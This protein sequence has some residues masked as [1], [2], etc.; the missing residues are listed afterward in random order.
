MVQGLLQVQQKVCKVIPTCGTALPR[1]RVPA[2]TW[3]ARE[4]KVKWG[5]SAAPCRA[6]RLPRGFHRGFP[7]LA[8]NQSAKA[9]PVT[10]QTGHRSSRVTSA[11]GR[12][13][14]SLCAL[15][16]TRPR[17]D[18]AA[19]ATRAAGRGGGGNAA[20]PR[21]PPGSAPRDGSCGAA[22]APGEGSASA[23]GSVPG[24]TSGTAAARGTPG[25]GR[26]RAAASG[27]VAPSVLPRA[28]RGEKQQ[29]READ[30]QLGDR[31]QTRLCS[32]QSRA[33]Q[34]LRTG[35]LPTG[36]GGLGQG[37]RKPR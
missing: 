30:L 5:S 34:C 32:R 35:S 24:T 11:R 10:I 20:K 16:R 23:D 27:A 25:G 18:R 37:P 7:S 28:R 17:G 3:T 33:P 29:L 19:P 8:R 1:T 14:P 21:K 9:P 2:S 13:D 22:Q 4:A 6:S 26:G 31:G 12:R 15:P 36:R